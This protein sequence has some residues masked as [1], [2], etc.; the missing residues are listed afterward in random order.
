MLVRG[1]IARPP[2]LCAYSTPRISLVVLKTA[3]SGSVPV[4]RAC[5]ERVC[6]GTCRVL[7]CPRA[8]P[9]WVGEG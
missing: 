2:Y 6:G 3:V 4:V 5:G 7:E 1:G 8:V 9:R